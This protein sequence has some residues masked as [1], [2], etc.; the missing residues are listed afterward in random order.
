M[1]LLQ[2][3]GVL[4]DFGGRRGVPLERGK[5][6]PGGIGESTP[7]GAPSRSQMGGALSLSPVAS[8]K[9]WKRPYRRG[10]EGWC[11]SPSRGSKPMALH[12]RRRAWA[13]AGSEG[14]G[15]VA[16]GPQAR[17]RSRRAGKV[18]SADRRAPRTFATTAR[19][20]GMPPTTW[21]ALR[22]PAVDAASSR[23]CR[24]RRD[25][26]DSPRSRWR[27]TRP[28]EVR[29]SR[30]RLVGARDHLARSAAHRSS[31]RGG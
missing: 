4:Q 20:A 30:E 21:E 24:C 27:R 23:R 2:Q 11:S 31:K 22:A 13:T 3:G 16:W 14:G 7:R 5:W 17:V 19:V 29:S 8:T 6:P 12:T 26:G 28:A 1:I 25:S 10:D 9:A 15:R 18:R